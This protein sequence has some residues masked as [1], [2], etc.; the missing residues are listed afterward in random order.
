[1]DDLQD[2][3]VVMA[4][5]S[6][7]IYCSFMKSLAQRTVKTL[8]K[9]RREHKNTSEKK[10]QSATKRSSPKKKEGGRF[11][12][13]PFPYGKM[14]KAPPPKKALVKPK[15]NLPSWT[16]YP[17]QSQAHEGEVNNNPKKQWEILQIPPSVKTFI[18]IS[19]L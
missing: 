11:Q 1:M 12:E 16:C 14:T 17:T 3:D 13:V 2:P 18:Q 7:L 9:A 8:A 4:L 10:M 15:G 5:Q 6:G 19:Y